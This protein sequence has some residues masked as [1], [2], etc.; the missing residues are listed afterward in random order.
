MS[1]RRYQ[2]TH[3]TIYGYSDVVTSSYGRGFLTPRETPRQRCLAHALHIDPVPHRVED[4]V[5]GRERGDL[6]LAAGSVVECVRVDPAVRLEPHHPLLFFAGA[7][8]RS[9]SARC[10]SADYVGL[11]AACRPARRPKKLDSP[12]QVPLE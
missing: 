9:P 6:V 2:V 3:S 5:D 7:R 11:L 10:A 1:T 12:M 4:G 8:L